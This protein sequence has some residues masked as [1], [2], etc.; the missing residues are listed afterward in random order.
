MHSEID[1]MERIEIISG[2]RKG[3]F[4]VLV[5]INLLR[6]GL[7][8]PEVELVAILD[9]DKEGFLRSEAALIQT[10]GRVARNSE[11]RVI[12]FADTI[13]KSMQKA[14]D[15]TARRRKIQDDYN[16]AHGIEPKTIKKEIV[17]T[18]EITKKVETKMKKED[19]SKEIERLTGL[20]KI[21]SNQLD[22][23]SAMQFRDEIN[24]LKKRLN[25]GER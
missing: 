2:L 20:M 9:A 5:G 19:I 15:E 1:T 18:L 11:G 24:A 12:L 8:L 7:D 16:K 21:A 17:N 4:D 10:I 13:T 3:D 14:I 25:K 23:E 22:F 6:E